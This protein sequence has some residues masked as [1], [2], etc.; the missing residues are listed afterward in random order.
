MKT[1]VWAFVAALLATPVAAQQPGGP[2]RGPDGRQ[3]G[4]MGGPGMQG[5]A[6]IE[7]IIDLAI[8]RR[9]SLK[10]SN[11]QVTKLRD[12][13]ADLGKR[14]EDLRA[15]LDEARQDANGDRQAMR[16]RMQGL[17]QKV[18][19][20][21]EEERKRF[22]GI[23]SEEQR[24]R[25]QALAPR[26]RGGRGG[27]PGRGDRAG[28]GARR[29]AMA[30]DGPAFGPPGGMRFRG[31]PAGPRFGQGFV[32]GWGRMGAG[33]ADMAYWRGWRDAMRAAR[34][35]FGPGARLDRF[36]DAR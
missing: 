14:R 23:L 30:P 18:Q 25:L 32:P 24:G 6:G 13:K 1:I 27:Q 22:E 26:G 29:G 36:R 8:E 4:P 9:D 7:R 5:P 19:A 34:R 35:S 33:A 20:G 28:A 2:G 21:R 15:Q 12:F 10:L 31:G 11:D 16:E 17:R 3:D